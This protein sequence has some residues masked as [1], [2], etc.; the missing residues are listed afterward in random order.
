MSAANASKM[1]KVICDALDI[2][3][4]G[5]NKIVVECEIGKVCMVYIR[6]MPSEPQMVRI[7]DILQV[8]RVDEVE[9]ADDCTVRIKP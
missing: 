2:N 4:I 3:S 7:A 9:V 8:H 5:V 6:G 1:C